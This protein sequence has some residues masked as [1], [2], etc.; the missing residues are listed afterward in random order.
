MSKIEIKNLTFGYDNQVLP[1]F[2][3]ATLNF[4]TTWKLGL[5]G[6]NGRGKTTLLN[7]LQ[8]KLPYQGQIIHQQEFNYFPQEIGEEAQFTYDALNEIADVELWEIERELQL[9]ETD[10]EILWRPFHTLSG[11]EKTK[12]LLALLFVDDQHFPLIDE[13]TNH[14]DLVGRKQVA[15]YLQ[16]KNQGFIVISHD[17]GFIDEVVDHVLAIEK[18]QLELYQGNFSVYEEQKQLKNEFEIAQNEKIKKEVTRLKKTAAEKAEWSR[19][20][21]G[22]KTKKSVGFIDTENRRVNRG[23][24]GA[25]A[26]RTMKRSKAIVNRMETQI[27]EKEKLLKDIEYI[28]SLTM[29]SQASHHKRLLSVE[30]LQLGYENL[31]FEP[32]HFTIEPHQRVAISGPNGAGKSSII[33]YLLGAFNGK[34]IGEKSQPKHLSISYVRQNYEDN[35]G[36]LAEFTEKNQVDYQAFLNNLRKL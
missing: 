6:R 27:S 5:I 16:K 34:V 22:D 1:L 8:D 4:D 10:P 24:I 3:Q 7:I 32:I 17:R 18:S 30:D 23:A 12:V 11:G 25:D 19:S 15:N 35:R 20:R 29:N 33:H 31:L 2:D 28:D 36:T 13:P 21:E 26:A 14:L 9:M